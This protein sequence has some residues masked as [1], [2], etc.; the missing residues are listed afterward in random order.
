MKPARLFC[1]TFIAL[2]LLG[3]PLPLYASTPQASAQATPVATETPQTPSAQAPHQPHVTPPVVTPAPAPHTAVATK[4]EDIKIIPH[5]AEYTVEL[6]RTRIAAN[7]GLDD[8]NDVRGTLVIQIADTGDGLAFEQH[9]TIQVYYAD[10]S[11]E[12]SITTVASWE[13]EDG[14]QYRFNTRS[15]RNGVEEITRGYAMSQKGL[16]GSAT[17]E[18]P[19]EFRFD[20]P[21]GTMFPLTHLKHIIFAAQHGEHGVP[22]KVVFDGS[23]GIQE[24]VEVNVVIGGAFDPKINLSNKPELLKVDKAFALQ[25]AVFPLGSKTTEADFEMGQKVLPSGI[26][27]AMAM[28]LGQ[29]GVPTKLTLSK[30]EILKS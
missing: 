5:R 18:E 22:G 21:I 29:E 16:I 26:I 24:P 6:D 14:Q 15:L 2:Q 13:S 28:D 11:M 1:F 10:G 8:I 9:A 3:T 12:Q 17:F 27:T 25:F 4:P 23:N 7:Q 20:L 19:Y 30:V